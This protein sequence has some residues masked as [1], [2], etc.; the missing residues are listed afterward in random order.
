MNKVTSSGQLSRI[1]MMLKPIPLFTDANH[2]KLN[3]VG[4]NAGKIAFWSSRSN[5]RYKPV[6]S[7]SARLVGQSNYFR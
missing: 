4:A 7:K 5:S 6:W 1:G 2:L 3:F